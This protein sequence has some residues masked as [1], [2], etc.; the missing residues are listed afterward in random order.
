MHLCYYELKVVEYD[1]Q[2]HMVS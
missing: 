1:E 2:Y